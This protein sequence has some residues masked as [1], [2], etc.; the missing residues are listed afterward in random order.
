MKKVLIHV[1]ALLCL[2]VLA[3]NPISAQQWEYSNNKEREFMS[4]DEYYHQLKASIYKEYEDATFS[5][6][7]KI[8]YKEFPDF[9]WRFEMKTGAHVNQPKQKL[10][11]TIHPDRQVYFF[12][13]FIQTKDKENWKYIVIDAESGKSLEGGS[14]FHKYENPYN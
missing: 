10:T 11:P 9:L 7:Q 4:E 8:P 3:V 2:L 1:I 12:G 6:R 5:M 13:T 14:R